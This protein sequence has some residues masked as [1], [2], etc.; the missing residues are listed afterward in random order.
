M[1]S[2]ILIVLAIV[3]FSGCASF[4]PGADPEFRKAD[5]L[6]NAKKFGDAEAAYEKISK[7]SRGTERGAD[8]LFFASVTYVYYDNPRKDYQKAFQSF[9]D[10]LR[11][12]PNNKMARDAQ[13]WRAILK[14]VLEM[15]KDN[16]RLTKS[17]EQLKRID[18]RHEERRKGK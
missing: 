11:A 14:T 4:S 8:A 5:E 12:Y 6:V 10:F 15:K 17:I 1:K 13:N 18:I 2:F 9:D 16:E 7:E 3:C